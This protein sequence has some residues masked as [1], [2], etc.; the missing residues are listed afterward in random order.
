M[1][2]VA[3][4]KLAQQEQHQSEMEGVP[5]SIPTRVTLSLMNLFLLSSMQAFDANIANFVHF[6]KTLLLFQFLSD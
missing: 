5:S 2:H 3:L 1:C 4:A 6:E